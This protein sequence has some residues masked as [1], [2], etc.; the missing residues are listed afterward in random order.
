MILLENVFKAYDGKP[1]VD[2]IDLTVPQGSLFGLIGPN[3]AGK[4]TTL[5]MVATLIKPDHGKVVV[6]GHD[7]ASDVR[8]A[9]RVLGYMPD[10][11]GSFRALTCEEYLEFFGRAYDYWG[12]ELTRRVSA[13]LELTDLESKRDELTNALSTGMKQRLALAKTLL[14]DPEILVLD[15]PASGL[16]PRARIEVRSLLKELGKMGKTVIISSHILADLEETCTDVAIIELGKVVWSG[17]LGE[18]RKEMR[19]Q[20]FDVAI[21]V[22]E[23]EVARAAELLKAVEGVEKVDLEGATLHAKLAARHGNRLLEAL[24]AA[25]IEVVSFSQEK[26]DLES[27]FLER[28][29]GIVS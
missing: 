20:R 26:I 16:D 29:K 9:R 3:G 14:H 18:A 27:I 19:A 4:T 15:E 11:F 2:G 6:R 10:Q 25:R 22:P 13:V 8:A 12:S 28:T 7:L 23:E 17:S 1:A 5:K 24:I 21:E